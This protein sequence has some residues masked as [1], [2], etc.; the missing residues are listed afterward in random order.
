MPDPKRDRENDF[1]SYPALSRPV[2]QNG[3]GRS[4]LYSPHHR[5]GPL[6]AWHLL[7]VLPAA[8]AVYA[9]LSGYMALTLTRPV[10]LPFERSPDQ[11]GL[12]FESVSFPSRIDAIKLDG[13]L[14]PVTGSQRRP[15]VIVHGKGSDRQQ[16]VGGRVLEIA[17]ALVLDGHPV[18]MFD[19]RG[20]GR[21]GGDHFTLG[22]EE[23]RDLG[24][25]I[26]FLEKRGL[27]SR[28]VD[29]LGYSMGAATAMLEAAA[30]PKVNV[31]AEDSG[32]ATLG[33]VVEDQVPKAS[34][35]PSVFTPG[36]VLAARLLIGIDVYSIR[37]IDA[38][39]TLAARGIPLLVIHGEA[40]TMIPVTN[41]HTLA[42]A[43]GSKVE[44]YFVPGAEH[45]G[46]YP[47]NPEAYLSHL[48]AFFDRGETQNPELRTQN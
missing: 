6:V 4:A 43:Y 30:D 21:S 38:A 36:V 10:R 46:S 26:D 19:L 40:D 11:Y 1:R 47:A 35:L 16:E 31:V 34:G 9:I 32:Y 24:G 44:S 22:A 13:W 27:A 23:V 5:P 42:A 20:S 2:V 45:V 15:V 8:V 12:T 33:E 28:G 48:T 3:Y 25:A 7:S 37:P 29:L 14:L 39:R 41:G 18:L 17:R